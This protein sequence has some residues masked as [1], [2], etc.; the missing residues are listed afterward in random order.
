MSESHKGSELKRLYTKNKSYIIPFKQSFSKQVKIIYGIK[1]LEY[2]SCMKR[3]E[4]SD[5]EGL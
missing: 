2:Y 1:K 5:E 4:I 3:G